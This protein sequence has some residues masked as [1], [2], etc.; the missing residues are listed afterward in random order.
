MV[1]FPEKKSAKMKAGGRFFAKLQK[2]LRL[3]LHSGNPKSGFLKQL[4][5]IIVLE[6]AGLKEVKP[7]LFEFV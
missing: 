1:H 7:N 6:Q 5:K 4:L 3:F 2:K